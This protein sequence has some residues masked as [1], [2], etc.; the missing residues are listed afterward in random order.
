MTLVAEVG[1]EMV[2]Q[3]VAGGVE[4]IVDNLLSN[5]LAVTPRGRSVV[6]GV[7]AE[8]TGGV[9]RVRDEGPGMKP[10]DRARAFD[11]FWRGDHSKP[12]SG[13]GLAIVRDL[14]ESSG[15]SAGLEATDNGG[16]EAVAAFPRWSDG[17]PPEFTR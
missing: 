15:G 3:S 4:E 8:G 17:P 6:V 10:E 1:S 16:I 12:G 13:L 11:R 14:A 7:S 5:A 2:V 9:L